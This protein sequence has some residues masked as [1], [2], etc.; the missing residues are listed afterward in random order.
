MW[1][2][3]RRRGPNGRGGAWSRRH[4]YGGGARHQRGGTR[5][6]RGGGRAVEGGREGGHMVED[7]RGGGVGADGCVE[8]T[9]LGFEGSG[10]LKKKNSSDAR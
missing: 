8:M 3:L 5:G 10:A 1:K 4:R 7:G 9:G 6:G 2:R